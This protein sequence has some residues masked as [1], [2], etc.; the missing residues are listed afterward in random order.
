VHLLPR[1]SS[2]SGIDEGATSVASNGP[3]T[4]AVV[5]KESWTAA[6]ASKRS[7]HGGNSGDDTVP[8][9]AACA[10]VTSLMAVRWWQQRV[11]ETK[12]CKVIQAKRR[13]LDL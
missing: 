13:V 2:G 12:F 1:W 7:W 5:S 3:E 8:M 4:A 6:V 10:P 11:R 9:A